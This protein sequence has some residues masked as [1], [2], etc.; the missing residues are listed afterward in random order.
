MNTYIRWM[1][2]WAYQHD[3]FIRRWRAQRMTQMVE[4]V[5]LR[6][7]QRVLDLGGTEQL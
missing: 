4:R 7:G 2:E 5:G 6:P 1:T 3:G